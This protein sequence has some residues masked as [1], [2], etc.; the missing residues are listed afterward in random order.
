LCN[1]VLGIHYI[2]SQVL[3]YSFGVINSFILNKIWTFESKGTKKKTAI[4]F[5]RFIIINIISLTISVFGIRI[6]IETYYV[7]V[8]IAKIV[9]TFIAQIVNYLGYKIWVFGKN[10]KKN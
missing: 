4:E 9:V 8:I 10:T 3:G 6:L 2:I 5:L 7:N 1:K